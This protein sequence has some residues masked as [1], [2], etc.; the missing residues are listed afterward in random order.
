M[1]QD[2]QPHFPE[3]VYQRYDRE[4]DK[5]LLMMDYSGLSVIALKAI[6]EQQAII[7]DLKNKDRQ[8]ELLIEQL[9]KRI[10]NLEKKN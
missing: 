3:L 10:E 9:I 2:I 8:K 4:K 7:D 1:A 5:P 6:Q